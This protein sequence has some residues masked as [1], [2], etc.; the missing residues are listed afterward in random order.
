MSARQNMPMQIGMGRGMHYLLPAQIHAG[1]KMNTGL[2]HQQIGMMQTGQQSHQF[3]LNDILNTTQTILQ[4]QKEHH[5]QQNFNQQRI[6]LPFFNDLLKTY[7]REQI[8][9]LKEL[10]EEQKVLAEQQ[11]SILEASRIV[12]R[13]QKE[14]MDRM[15]HLEGSEKNDPVQVRVATNNQGDTTGEVELRDGMGNLEGSEKAVQVATNNQGDTTGEAIVR[16]R[17]GHLEESD[18]VA[19]VVTN[20]Q[21]VTTGEAIVR[22]RMGHL[23]GSDNVVQVAVN[24]QDGTAGKAELS[25]KRKL[26]VV[27]TSDE[28]GDEE[29]EALINE[30]EGSINEEWDEI[31]YL[32]HYGNELGHKSN[33]GLK[34]R[35]REVRGRQSDKKSRNPE[36]NLCEV[37]D[38]SDK[39][40]RN[41]DPNSRKVEGRQSPEKSRKGEKVAKV[42]QP[43]GVFQG[44]VE[45]EWENAEGKTI[46]RIKYEDSDSE[47]MSEDELEEAICYHKYLKDI[48]SA[49]A[50]AS[51]STSAQKTTPSTPQTNQNMRHRS[52]LQNTVPPDDV[53]NETENDNGDPSNSKTNQETMTMSTERRPEHDKHYEKLDEEPEAAA[54]ERGEQAGQNTSRK[55]ARGDHEDESVSTSLGTVPDNIFFRI[56]QFSHANSLCG[57]AKLCREVGGVSKELRRKCH[58]TLTAVPLDI[59]MVEINTQ[60]RRRYMLPALLWVK[61][62]RAKLRSLSVFCS[63]GDYGIVAQVLR[64]CDV[65]PIEE[66]SIQNQ[67][68]SIVREYWYDV[69]HQPPHHTGYTSPKPWRAMAIECGIQVDLIDSPS[70]Y[71]SLLSTIVQ[72]AASLK[73]L[74]ISGDFQNVPS[75]DLLTRLESLEELKLGINNDRWLEE[76]TDRLGNAISAMTHL[77]KLTLLGNRSRV[78]NFYWVKSDTLE[79][80]N[81]VGMG[82][83]QWFN[84]VICPSLK[85]FESKA[86]TFGNGIRPVIPKARTRD[87]AEFQAVSIQPGAHLACSLPCQGVQVPDSCI[88]KFEDY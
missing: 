72:H 79:E 52:S 33:G 60:R 7:Q 24:N 4:Q 3:L 78:A 85:L 70:T 26:V 75:Y 61:E 28:D 57:M 2:M 54:Q 11:K 65:L 39:K 10:F 62:R 83:G 8:L 22:H 50:S 41:P 59:N 58:Q 86:Y 40:S 80:I 45:N 37:R 76:H 32:S 30:I 19:Q 49:S 87:A 68:S 25:R 56:A 17:M 42:F 47:D 1:V 55:K 6:L 14:L 63:V 9:G 27:W 51:A 46:Y 21:G 48:R 18:N 82:K 71:E 69:L 67:S 16:H 53:Q 73:K 36:P 77:K 66:L 38:R 44:M 20:N 43:L 23:E 13:Q 64:D 29:E 74:R 15:G 88:F 5:E 34:S 12:I 31:R 84:D 35:L 81:V